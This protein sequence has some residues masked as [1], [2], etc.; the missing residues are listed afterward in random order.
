MAILLVSFLA[1]IPLSDLQL[2]DTWRAVCRVE[3]GGDPRAVGD[4]G[5]AVGIAQIHRIMVD[6]CNRIVGEAR[7]THADRL[8]PVKSREMF[9]LF[10]L[11]Y[12]G[13]GGPEQW[14]RAWNGGPRGPYKACTAGYW[15]KVRS[16]MAP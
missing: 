6:D 14:A 12:H 3:S 11:R 9:R 10:C 5:R 15:G 16:A 7:W 13:R 1:S 4:G 8:S 2:E